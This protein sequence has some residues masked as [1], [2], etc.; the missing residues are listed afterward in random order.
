MHSKTDTKTFS[1]ALSRKNL[2][3]INLNFQ[4]EQTIDRLRRLEFMK[5][6]E[7]NKNLFSSVKEK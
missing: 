5:R 2:Q 4:I 1:A 3:N 6:S 7:N